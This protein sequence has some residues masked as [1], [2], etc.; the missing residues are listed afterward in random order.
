[1]IVPLTCPAS[2]FQLTRSPILKLFLVNI[3]L[4]ILRSDDA[5]ALG[6]THRQGLEGKT[7]HCPAAEAEH[8]AVLDLRRSRPALHLQF[9]EHYLGHTPA[10]A[11]SLNS[12]SFPTGWTR[13]AGRSS[14]PAQKS[15][16]IARFSS[17]ITIKA[18]TAVLFS[19][20]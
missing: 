1:M 17:P 11:A 8:H 2:E 20:G 10:A 5:Q 7:G 4:N 12:K 3:P 6:D 14:L 15:R 18:A 9:G 13:V 16:K 19:A